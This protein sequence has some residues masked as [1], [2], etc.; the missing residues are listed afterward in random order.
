[1]QSHLQQP[2]QQPG[3]CH[4]F[5]AAGH[6]AHSCPSVARDRAVVAPPPRVAMAPPQLQAAVAAAAATHAFPARHPPQ[7]T[8][9]AS[10]AP[11]QQQLTPQ[12]QQ[13][14]MQMQMQMQMQMLQQTMQTKLERK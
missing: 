8:R 9:P 12:M 10:M 2:G 14:M 11:Q 4:C 13:Q 3:G 5:S 1:M 6:T 7:I